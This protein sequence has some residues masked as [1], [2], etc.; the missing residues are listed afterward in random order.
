MHIS[1]YY[2]YIREKVGSCG[3]CD[4]SIIFTF[5]TAWMLMP[6]T[7]PF[8]PLSDYSQQFT[9]AIF[10]RR[11]MKIYM[12]TNA[13]TS[14]LHVCICGSEYASEFKFTSD[15]NTQCNDSTKHLRWPAQEEASNGFSYNVCVCVWVCLDAYL[16]M[17]LL[18]NNTTIIN[19]NQHWTSYSCS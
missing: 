7:F 9:L 14:A 8:I 1:I 13:H 19:C 11:K 3:E 17:C 16:Y 12:L 6:Q 2:I 5:S 10:F 18:P 4:T 15:C